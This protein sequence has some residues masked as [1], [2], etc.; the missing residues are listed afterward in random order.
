M[1]CVCVRLQEE[2]KQQAAGAAAQGSQR[3]TSLMPSGLK[4]FGSFRH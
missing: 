3:S 1:S 4:Q 2:Q